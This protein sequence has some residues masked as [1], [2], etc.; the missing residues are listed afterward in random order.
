M[1]R[2]T[3][4]ALLLL[5]AVAVA[6]PVPKAVKKA[7]PFPY[8]VGTKWEYTHNGNAKDV[9]VEEVVES[10]EKD[11]AVTFKVDITAS[12][13]QKR[14]ETYRLK[15]GVLELTATGNG[16]FDPPMLI[17]KAGMKAGDEWET[18]YGYAPK[19]CGT[20]ADVTLTVG[21]AE[22]ITTPAGKFTATP[23]VRTTKG[24]NGNAATTFWFADGVG[25]IRQT[26]PGQKEPL[27]DLKAFTPGKK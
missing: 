11:G 7:D 18:S 25:M 19:G 13:G 8:A 24:P 22:E 17:A 23:V 16:E 6:A 27:Q 21:K 1:T 5:A 14:S 15:D 3:P 12:G 10:A 2:F 4:V 9:W 20:T 26:S